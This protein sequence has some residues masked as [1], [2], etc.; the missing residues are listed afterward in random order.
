MIRVMIS[1]VLNLDS[2]RPRLLDL[3]A[4]LG[5]SYLEYVFTVSNAAWAMSLDL[6]AFLLGLC[7]SEQPGTIADLGSGFSS[8][9]FRTYAREQP[10]VQVVSIDDS[11][12]WLE[13]TRGFLEQN[14][15]STESLMG[16]DELAALPRE[17]F[18]LVFHDLGDMAV[19][20]ETLETAIGSA[21]RDGI[22]VLDD[23]H[24]WGYPDLVA[25]S[26]RAHG[27]EIVD[28]AS[29]TRDE[30]GRYAWALGPASETVTRSA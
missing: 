20:A 5:P 13:R 22:V 6:A 9:V 24:M 30:I 18:D 2:V 14:D 23:L 25:K 27:R 7:R 11:P 1:T 12:Q 21:R 3:K 26:A 4:E 8:Y 17:S 28:L 19:R 29:L 16:A 15:L 10:G